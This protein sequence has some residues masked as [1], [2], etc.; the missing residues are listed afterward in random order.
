MIHTPTFTKLNLD[1]TWLCDVL[2]QDLNAST[3]QFLEAATTS[4]SGRSADQV[5]RCGGPVHHIP[6]MGLFHC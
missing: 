6:S 4:D 5:P 3:P 1:T 2:G